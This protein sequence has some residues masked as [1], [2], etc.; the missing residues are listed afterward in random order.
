VATVLKFA[1]IA[2]MRFQRQLCGMNALLIRLSAGIALAILVAIP[3]YL[4]LAD[5]PE[6]DKILQTRYFRVPPS[7]IADSKEEGDRESWFSKPMNLDGVEDN[8]ITRKSTARKILETDGVTFPHGAAAVYFPDALILGVRNTPENMHK[9][10]G[11]MKK[12]GVIGDVPLLCIEARIVEYMPDVETKLAGRGTFAD[13]EA[14]LGDSV[15]TVCVSSVITKSGQHAEGR[16]DSSTSKPGSAQNPSVTTKQVAEESDKWPPPAGVERA[17]LE[18]EPTFMPQHLTGSEFAGM[19]IRFQY[20][21]PAGS[22]Q[23]AMRTELTTNLEISDGCLLVAKTFTISDPLNKSPNP[24]R[25][26]LMVSFR[27]MTAAG[28]TTEQVREEIQKN[29]KKSKQP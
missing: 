12:I 2:R 28:K 22:G 25:Y 15:K 17:L 6:S 16:L 14:K 19:Q 27:K 20:A 1:R 10:A 8:E 3:S 23:P 24:R 21:A 4:L 9:V 7:L 11:I 18:V 5:E 13:L 29:F 26:A